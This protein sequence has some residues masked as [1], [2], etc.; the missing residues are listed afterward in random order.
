[1]SK[2]ATYLKELL[3][4]RGEPIASVARGSGVERTSIH[5]ALKDERTL[6][7]MALRSLAQYLQL[8]LPQVRELN[9][10]YEMLIQGEEAYLVQGA[11]C[12]TLIADLKSQSALTF[13]RNGDEYDADRA[14]SHLAMKLDY[15]AADLPDVKSFIEEVASKSSFSGRDYEV[16]YP[17]GHRE[18]ARSYLYRPL[19][20]LYPT[21]TP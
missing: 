1:M 5:K 14:A 11:I 13:V 4:A 3:D 20:E 16:I 12:D 7:Y 17:D 19:K 18:T 2:F 10:R 15:A 9:E 6:S 8:S 21:Y